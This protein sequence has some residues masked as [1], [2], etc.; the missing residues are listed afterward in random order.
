MSEFTAPALPD[1]GSVLT[2]KL[3]LIFNPQRVTMSYKFRWFQ[4]L[5]ITTAEI[6]GID[7]AEQIIIPEAAL[8]YRMIELSAEST[9]R[10]RIQYAVRDQIPI[11]CAL[12][13]E[14][15]SELKGDESAAGLRY[16]LLS[17]IHC[18]GEDR[19]EECVRA[20]LYQE[21]GN[22]CKNSVFKDLYGK[23]RTLAKGTEA[24]GT[25]V[26]Y[27]L[28]SP[29]IGNNDS[30]LKTDITALVNS[31]D[32]LLRSILYTERTIPAALVK[33]LNLPKDLTFTAPDNS[34]VTCV[35]IN[36]LILPYLMRHF[37]ILSDYTLCHLAGHL[38][39][40]NI[41]L[42]ALLSKLM[43]T[44]KRESLNM[45]HKY[46]DSYI[47]CCGS[48]PD[49]Y[50]PGES[51][52]AGD[53]YALDHFMPWNFVRHNMIWNL[54]PITPALNSGKSD[55]IPHDRDLIKRLSS[56][57]QEVLLFHIRHGDKRSFETQK[58]EFLDIGGGRSLREIANQ[59]SKD[60]HAMLMQ[61]MEIVI[62]AAKL[63]GF[64][65]WPDDDKVFF[66]DP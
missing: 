61:H 57:H 48:V 56:M 16:C 33:R 28:L 23:I 8:L 7:R 31:T 20:L 15:L 25:Y 3:S 50:V 9:E 34:P 29:W 60:F 35:L 47:A 2:S 39:K 10:Y 51:F 44:E 11:L 30:I 6:Y 65:P 12:R 54:A 19:K 24:L 62:R 64:R 14:I 5:L 40:Y 42:P 38:E 13:R 59:S 4:S 46:F 37:R 52:K 22:H 27:R 41:M 66:N 53:E 55:G 32:P 45:Q 43:P 26:V 21:I 1:S 63:H 58:T 18:R 49:I 17:F 36:P